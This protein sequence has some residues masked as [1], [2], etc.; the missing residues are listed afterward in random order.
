[1]ADDFAGASAAFA[2]STDEPA[3][4]AAP[5]TPAGGDTPADGAAV[6]APAESQAPPPAPA[7]EARESVPWG[8]FHKVQQEAAKYRPQAQAH[9]QAFSG[10]HPDDVNTL[11]GVMQL[12]AS[13]PPAGAKALREVADVFGPEV[14]DAI[15]QA[16]TPDDDGDDDPDRP[17]TRREFEQLTAQQHEQQA[18]AAEVQRLHQWAQEKGLSQDDYVEVLTIAA[19]HTNN[20]VDAA[21]GVFT[22]R[23][24]KAVDDY[25]AAKQ[26]DA[27]NGVSVPDGQ[28]PTPAGEAPKTFDDASKGLKAYLASQ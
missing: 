22:G 28:A 21:L 8:E 1:M 5:E 3:P 25:L 15:D 11:L 16:A 13:D 20:D 19:S 6:A 14:A 18:T 12:L 17:M 4:D 10:F 9:E 23:R 7:E 26:A 2:A 27:K 24:Q